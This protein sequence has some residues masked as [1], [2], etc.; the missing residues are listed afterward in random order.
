MILD[1]D[2]PSDFTMI[3]YYQRWYDIPGITKNVDMLWNVDV[4]L[5]L[6]YYI[7]GIP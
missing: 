1:I 3:P 4:C 6:G 7:V 2:Q 5:K